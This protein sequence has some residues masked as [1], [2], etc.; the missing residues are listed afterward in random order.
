MFKEFYT[1]VMR[2]DIGKLQQAFLRADPNAKDVPIFDNILELLKG[3][4]KNIIDDKRIEIP[5]MEMLIA[6][7][8]CQDVAGLNNGR[9]QYTDCVADKLQEL[10]DFDPFA[11]VPALSQLRDGPAMRTGAVCIGIM[12][13]TIKKN[14]VQTIMENSKNLICNASKNLPEMKKFMNK[15]GYMVLVLNPDSQN[16]LVPQHR[17]RCYIIFRLY[18]G[19]GLVSIAEGLAQMKLTSITHPINHL[20]SN[21]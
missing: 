1:Q 10:G 3:T 5:D 14:I 4:A 2:C 11:D 16:H 12:V 20:I 21:M 13:L 17:E 18:E 19:S 7:G 8:P 6:C 9:G 15:Y